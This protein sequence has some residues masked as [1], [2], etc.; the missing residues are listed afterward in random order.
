MVTLKN[1]NEQI[2][3]EVPEERFR[4]PSDFAE[5][6]AIVRQAFEQGQKVT[7]VGALHS[8]TECI[9]GSGIVISMAK[10]D[11][12]LEIN[13]ANERV[14]VQAGVTLRQLCDALKGARL[15]PPVVLEFGNFQIGAISGT[16]ANDT[17]ITRGAQ[18]SSFVV[19][20]KLV[21][22]TGDIL[23]ISETENSERLPLA[24]SH[25]GLLGVVC[26][27]T[28]Q[29]FKNE[30]L[31][32]TTRSQ[33]I[34]HFLEHFEQEL[35]ELKATQDQVLGMLFPHTGKLLW[36]CRKFVAPDPDGF[37][38]PDRWDDVV[39][40]KGIYL[41]KDVLLPLVKAGAASG[42]SGALAELISRAV[43]ELPMGL[44][45]HGSYVIDPCDRGIVYQKHDPD[46]D[47]YD[48]VFPEANWCA[49]VRALLEL[50]G[51]FRRE[52]DFALPLP[53]LIY[54]IPRDEAS[55]LSRARGADMLA[56]DPTYPDPGDPDW[57][58][59][60]RAFN[61]IAAQHGGIPHINKT[62][63]GAIHHFAAACDQD[64][65]RTY[66]EARKQLDPKDL[67]LNDFFRTMFARRP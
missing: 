42:A 13:V 30:P 14:T 10:M 59:F 29:V 25:F 40:Q 27:V 61:E 20:M 51:R 7:V 16:H 38:P 67:F 34:E 28:L 19:G 35:A 62:R 17:A 18:F 39:Q 3:F 55:L 47:F 53:V 49:M 50:A 57:H 4:E 37:L 31:R 33:E 32:I 56:V 8:T 48:W 22:P 24:R 65:L 1:W 21:T 36:E 66:L 6:Q 12:V 23:E 58:T 63:D 26:E 5:V 11:Q 46:F 44:F 9:V 43:I 52:R 60:R 41:F 64:A 45:R 2:T 15:Q 54:F